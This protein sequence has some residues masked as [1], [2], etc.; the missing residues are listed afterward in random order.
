MAQAGA[1]AQAVY[2][3]GS[4]ARLMLKTME[5]QSGIGQ[6]SVR[7]RLGCRQGSGGSATAPTET[8]RALTALMA[9]LVTAA[10]EAGTQGYG[11]SWEGLGDMK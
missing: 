2:T 7:L 10:A 9:A 3:Q 1:A 11:K 4:C 8:G 5:A 6:G